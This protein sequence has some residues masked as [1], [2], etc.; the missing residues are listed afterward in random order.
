M[1][2]N[3]NIVWNTARNMYVVAS[4]FAQGD[5][6]IKSQ[7]RAAGIATLLGLLSGP[8]MAD[9]TPTVAVGESVTGETLNPVSY[10][11]LDVYKRQG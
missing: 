3:F 6:Q 7:A 5:S 11:H 9:Y 4:E 2:K 1:N 8:A 10:T